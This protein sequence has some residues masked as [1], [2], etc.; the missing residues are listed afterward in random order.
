[1]DEA[2]FFSANVLVAVRTEALDH[3][4]LRALCNNTPPDPTPPDSASP[5]RGRVLR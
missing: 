2:D 1:M 5:E 3:V 4:L